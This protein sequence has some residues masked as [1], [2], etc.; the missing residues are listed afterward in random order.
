MSRWSSFLDRVD[1]KH[2]RDIEREPTYAGRRTSR[3]ANSNRYQFAAAWQCT[4]CGGQN[5]CECK[6]VEPAE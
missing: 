6:P 3:V 1:A 5:V 2:D 4:A